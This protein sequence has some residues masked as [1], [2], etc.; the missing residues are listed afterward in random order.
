M[1]IKKNSVFSQAADK[2]AAPL[3]RVLRK[4]VML[5]SDYELLMIILTFGLLIVTILNLRNK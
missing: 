1:G 2:A 4:G 5:M 3:L